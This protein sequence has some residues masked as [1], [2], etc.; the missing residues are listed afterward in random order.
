MIMNINY[1]SIIKNSISYIFL[2]LIFLTKAFADE[3]K[4]SKI[5]I[6]I[7]VPLTGPIA[8]YGQAIVRG[9]QLAEKELHPRFT[10]LFEDTQYQTP[11]A[12]SAY[13]KVRQSGATII[14]QWGSA[15][16]E[17]L[18]NLSER[19]KLP[20]IVWTGD[21]STIT[22]KKFTI[23][24]V[25]APEFFA[26]KIVSHESFKE[27]DSVAFLVNE[28]P[29]TLG[30]HKAVKE[31]NSIPILFEETILHNSDSYRSILSKL[32]AKQPKLIGAFLL[33]PDLS[34]FC[35]SMRDLQIRAT[36]FGTDQFETL[37]AV[38]RCEPVL[39]QGFF[40]NHTQPDSF[41][42]KYLQTYGDDIQVPDASLAYAL[43]EILSSLALSPLDSSEK[44]M[45]KLHSIKNLST[46]KGITSI[47][48]YKDVHYLDW[49][50]VVRK[51]QNGK[52][53]NAE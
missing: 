11:Q 37:S 33:E 15:P 14:Y 35:R 48:S 18:S 47:N 51:I 32:K 42:K 38:K 21:P 29:Y 20:L 50:I 22:Q 8:E 6:G 41:T 40:A 36:I 16:A 49:P 52:I 10:F 12:I 46:I 4:E 5:K 23:N 13:E 53:L 28:I 25:P 19:Y 30:L 3:A 31:L 24:A 7:L 39:E 44:I 17:T 27:A 1:K 26:K 9:I 45:G 43:V 2:S 34:K